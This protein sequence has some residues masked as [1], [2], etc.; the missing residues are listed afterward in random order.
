MIVDLLRNDAGRVAE[1]GSVRV[2]RLF[3]VERYETVHQMTSTIRARAAAGRGAGG[4]LSR[5]LSLRLRHRR[6]Q[7]A[8]DARSSASWRPVAARRRTAARSASRR[9]AR[10]CSA[11]AS[12]RCCWTRAAGDGGAGRGQRH[13]LRQRRGRPSTASAGEGRLRPP[14]AR[15]L[16]RCW[17]RCCGS[18]RADGSCWT[19]TWTASPPPPR[20]FGFRVRRG[21]CRRARLA[22]PAPP[23]FDRAPMRVAAAAGP[24]R[25]DGVEARA[26]RRLGRAGARRRRGGAGGQPRSPALPQDHAPRASTSAAPPPAP[27]AT[28]CCW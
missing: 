20:Y 7:G 18:R 24:G 2:E 28:T 6:A 1:F 22:A 26:A 15:R 17:R 19:A 8:H 23:A 25:V 5:A 13:H 4:R 27:T 14:R 12:A 3:E 10:R 9:R 21:G 11:S 16:P